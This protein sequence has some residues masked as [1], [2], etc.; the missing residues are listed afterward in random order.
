MPNRIPRNA[1]NAVTAKVTITIMLPQKSDILKALN[2]Y[3]E[4]RKGR[5][6]DTRLT[7]VDKALYIKEQSRH[8]PEAAQAYIDITEGNE[9][10]NDFIRAVQMAYS[11][12]WEKGLDVSSSHPVF[13][14]DLLGALPH[15]FEQRLEIRH[16]EVE[17]VRKA[18]EARRRVIRGPR[19]TEGAEP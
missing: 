6:Y 16:K 17:E 4:F 2:T 3:L 5:I 7:N 9:A 1:I 15:E 10:G 19:G 12:A 18:E 14:D 13:A 11:K 8:I